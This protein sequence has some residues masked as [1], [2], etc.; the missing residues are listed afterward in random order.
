[1]QQ[2]LV[3]TADTLELPDA[4][5][6]LAPPT[7]P[8]TP[9][10]AILSPPTFPGTK[11]LRHHTRLGK[12]GQQIFTNVCKRFDP[13]P[14]APILN[15][16]SDDGDSDGPRPLVGSSTDG[17]GAPRLVPESTDGEDDA[18]T[19]HPRVF[20]NPRLGSKT[21]DSDDDGSTQHAEFLKAAAI[22]LN[23]EHNTLLPT[24][25]LASA[26][27]HVSG[28]VP[29]P[30]DEP[31][32][33]ETREVATPTCFHTDFVFPASAPQP[34]Q[35]RQAQ[36]RVG[37]RSL[38]ERLEPARSFRPGEAWRR[39]PAHG[40]C[41]R[42]E[43]PS[44][45]EGRLLFLRDRPEGFHC[46][47]S[48]AD[49]QEVRPRPR[50]HRDRHLGGWGGAQLVRQA[51]PGRVSSARRGGQ[52]RHLHPQPALRD[53]VPSQLGKQ[54]GPQPCRN[55]ENP[56]GLPGQLAHQAR[57]AKDG[58]EFI[59][60]SIRVV[61]AA[62][63]ARA[64]GFFVRS[65]L[66]HPEDLGRVPTGVPA[67][68]WQLDDIRQAHGSSRFW[69][70]AGY[71]CQ[72]PNCDRSKPTRL[73]SDLEGV[74]EFGYLG[75]PVFDP[76]N[77]YV[78][79]LPD[80]CGHTGANR[81]KQK[82]IGRSSQGGFNTSPTAAYPAGMCLFIANL[83]FRNWLMYCVNIKPRNFVPKRS[84]CGGGS[85]R[86]LA[87]TSTTAPSSS[88]TASPS[89]PATVTTLTGNWEGPLQLTHDNR[90]VSQQE[91]EEASEKVDSHGVGTPI[92]DELPTAPA[93][94]HLSLPLAKSPQTRRPSFRAPGGRARERAGTDAGPRCVPSAKVCSENSPTGLAS[95]H[96]GDG[97][98]NSA[99]YPTTT[100]P[101]D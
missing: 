70:V 45:A 42:A 21:I 27:V 92:K 17:E 55:R 66:E 37:L 87:T 6:D 2:P 96:Q 36:H 59:H 3:R 69:A 47:K 48:G 61:K 86:S 88:H 68:I 23:A 46:T 18:S 51:A 97:Q 12:Q 94:P 95:A 84:P 24:Q 49:V 91:I 58:N 82:M 85:Q 30:T 93:T 81:H 90:L 72:F 14:V 73:L 71:Q 34:S 99:G 25:D 52:L 44:Y 83:I 100:P 26:P 67:S 9:P 16:L 62:C 79:P 89:S 1:M 101:D 65:L 4:S 22:I 5:T 74:E 38:A 78:G 53:L 39:F 31:G 33:G 7:F 32:E 19:S 56:W 63:A 64:R 77:N 75:W 13:T 10:P 98:S 80:S 20:E 29:P 40:Y 41:P 50:L 15:G 35:Q 54:A 57:R 43:G 28:E 11:R 76:D 60:F 8:P